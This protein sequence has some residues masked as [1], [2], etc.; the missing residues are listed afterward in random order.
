MERCLEKEIKKSKLC[1]TV[2]QK[3]KHVGRGNKNMRER[4]GCGWG[5]EI[6]QKSCELMIL[7]VG[8]FAERRVLLDHP[9]I[10]TLQRK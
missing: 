7:W 9:W 6:G 8:Y 5:R 1:K 2:S 3:K 4:N 10:Q